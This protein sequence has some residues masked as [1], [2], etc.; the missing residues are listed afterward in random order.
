VTLAAHASG[1]WPGLVDPHAA[2]VWLDAHDDSLDVRSLWLARLSLAR[3]VGGDRL[4]L[5]RTRDRI[6]AKLHHGLS[7]ER[8]VPTFLRFLGQTGGAKGDPALRLVSVLEDLLK[9][10]E[11]TA[12]K[13]S[14]VE[15]DPAM[16]R[17]YVLFVF[18]YGFARLGAADRARALRTTA[19][20]LL[21]QGKAV[22]GYLTRAFSSRIEQALEGL[23]AETPLSPEIQAEL[24]SLEKFLR[25]KVD[26]LRQA[27][28]ILE[29]QEHLDPIGAFTRAD[30]DPRG[31]EFA[32]LRGMTDPGKLRAEVERLMG[33]ALALDTAPEESDRLF[34]GLMDFFPVL[35]EAAAIPLLTA[36]VGNVD[37]VGPVR[38]F[39]LLEEALMLA[40]YFGRQDLVR[41]IVGMIDGLLG[42]LGPEEANEVGSAVGGCLKSLRRVGLR[43]EAARLLESVSAVLSGTSTAAQVARL[44]VAGGFAFLGRL[45]RATPDFERALKSLSVAPKRS[46]TEMQVEIVERTQITRACAASL[47]QTP[48]E[49]AAAGIMRMAGQLSFVTD[50]FNTNDYFCQSVVSFMEALVLGLASEDLALGEFGRRWLD[51]EE[52]LVRRRIQR[53]NAA[54][55]G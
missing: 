19:A 41:R 42:T 36:V 4:G 24:A 13:R 16:T 31:A 49:M 3:L 33:V 45:D 51:E 17:A 10:F 50:S 53:D 26:R 43:E 14:A 46:G 11:K 18:A 25:Y 52:Y 40:G 8:D 30:K 39:A 1:D 2:Q 48:Q 5:A 28:S 55:T 29:P 37:D 21:P 22:H 9:H 6:L 54:A 44:H 32:G 7:L 27:S 35:G 12:R 20:G 38:R 23:P 34:D 47:S 15:A